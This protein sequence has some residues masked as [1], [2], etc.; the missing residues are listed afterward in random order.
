M[1]GTL[2]VPFAAIAV[3]V[4]SD[5]AKGIWLTLAAIAIG[6]TIYNVW[7]RERKKILTL[8]EKLEPKIKLFC[9]EKLSGCSVVT[10]FT[11][12]RPVNFLRIKVE[13]T[14]NDAVEKCT[15]FIT[16]IKKGE[17]V[18]ME[19]ES[20]QITFAPGHASDSL[21]KT[22]YPMVPA[23]LDALAILESNLVLVPTK[24]FQIPTS[25]D[26]RRVFEELGQYTL[27]VVVSG[28][29]V[30]SQSIDVQFNW[31]GVWNTATLTIRE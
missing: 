31:T 8:Y 9:G 18:I 24:G 1:S 10:K 25:L 4:S 17:K 16:S 19:H 21:G 5:Y 26:L 28:S 15:G 13:V 2:S 29:G 6:I 12:Q 14:G 3:F 11:D 23:F 7:A 30:P 27:C 20:L 22:I